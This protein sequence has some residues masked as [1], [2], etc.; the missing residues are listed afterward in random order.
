MFRRRSKKT[1]KLL[2][3]GLCEGNSPLID[4]FTAQRASN[5]ENVSNGWRLMNASV[6]H[7]MVN[8][9]LYDDV[10]K[11]KHFPRNWPFVR[12]IHRSRWI[13]TQRLVTWSFDVFFDLRLNKRLSKQPGGWWFE[14]PSWLLWRQCNGNNNVPLHWRIYL[15]PVAYG[16]GITS[17]IKCG[18]K[19]LI[20]S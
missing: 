3:T 2:L 14:T 20:H 5:A 8:R 4:E 1:S 10:I 13:P 18:M 16:E 6:L 9:Y 17:I 19:L 12:G 11:W 7:M 15:S